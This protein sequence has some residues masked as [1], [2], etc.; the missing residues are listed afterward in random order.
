[1]QPGFFVSEIQAIA[2]PQTQLIPPTELLPSA[3]N[4]PMRPVALPSTCLPLMIFLAVL[5]YW[6]N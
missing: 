4:V 2:F 5:F 3:F 6:M 1:V